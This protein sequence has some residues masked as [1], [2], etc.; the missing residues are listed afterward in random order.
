MKTTIL[1]L[2]LLATAAIAEG[3][4]PPPEIAK[5]RDAVDATATAYAATLQLN[6]TLEATNTDLQAQ[7][8]DTAKQL[9]DARAEIATLK[10]KLKQPLPPV[11]MD[12][13]IAWLK[14]WTQDGDAQPYSLLRQMSAYP[15]SSYYSPG[16]SATPGG[17][18]RYTLV[19][20][21][22]SLIVPVIGPTKATG[23][24]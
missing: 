5:L 23:A 4:A 13:L 10:D 7:L 16:L 9:A 1:S 22:N 3:P 17:E 14:S 2:L 11:P 24:Q 18:D 19:C 15:I 12:P 6:G 21:S 20:L 8:L